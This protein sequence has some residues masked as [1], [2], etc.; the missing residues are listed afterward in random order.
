MLMSLD[1]VEAGKI[2]ASVVAILSALALAWKGVMWTVAG[3]RGVRGHDSRF[4]PA[5]EQSDRWWGGREPN[6]MTSRRRR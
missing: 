3:W 6:P 5:I 1:I 4:M 2:A